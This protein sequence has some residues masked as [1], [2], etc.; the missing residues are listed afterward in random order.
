MAN[1]ICIL[2]QLT[3]LCMPPCLYT[4]KHSHLHPVQSSAPSSVICTQFS[5]L[6]PVQSSAPSS[7]ICTQ[8][9]QP[10]TY[11][12]LHILTSLLIDI[13][14]I[15]SSLCFRKYFHKY[16]K[17][18]GIITKQ[19]PFRSYKGPTSNWG[20]LYIS[21][22]STCTCSPFKF[23]LSRSDLYFLSFVFI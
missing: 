4:C 16:E 5:H 1:V 19:Y 6:H 23:K 9:S 10:S 8:Y 17:R 18:D 2:F 14:W 15:V 20:D 3:Y 22:L 11:Y 12:S 7:V 13:H 21:Q